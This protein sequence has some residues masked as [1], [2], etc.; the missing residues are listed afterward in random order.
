MSSLKIEFLLGRLNNTD[1]NVTARFL[2]GIA[3]FSASTIAPFEKI[4]ATKALTRSE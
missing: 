2:D 4:F 1:V 3:L